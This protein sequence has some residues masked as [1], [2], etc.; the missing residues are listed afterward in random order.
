MS[1]TIE[2][3]GQSVLGYFLSNYAENMEF[4]LSIDDYTFSSCAETA[5]I[6][7]NEL[8][9][10][11]QHQELYFRNPKEALAIAAFQVKIAGDVES[12][13]ASG[14]DGYYQKIRD[15]YPQ[16]KNC[17][18][19]AEIMNSY[20]K[21]NQ[22]EL[23][24]AVKKLFASY[25]RNLE[26]PEDHSGTGKYVQY[27]V[28]AHEIPNTQLLRYADTFIRR[29]LLPNQLQISYKVFCEMFFS[30]FVKE[31]Y[32]RTVWNFYCIWDGR[33]YNE[34]ITRTKSS[35]S[36]KS[37]REKFN[38]VLEINEN[39]IYIYDKATGENIVDKKLIESFLYSNSNL[40]YFKEYDESGLY[41]LCNEPIDLGCEIVLLTE[42]ELPIDKFTIR[43]IHQPSDGVNLY[44]YICKT[45]K[46]LCSLLNL[47]IQ[48]VKAPIKF[49]GGL[50][51]RKGHYYDFALPVIEFSEEQ[52]KAFIN[53]VEVEINGNRIYLEEIKNLLKSNDGT[54]T[55]KLP[56]Y[57]PVKFK[58][59]RPERVK[60][61]NYDISGWSF[62]PYSVSPAQTEEDSSN[63]INGFCTNFDFTPIQNGVDDLGVKSSG[64]NFIKQ[65]NRFENRFLNKNIMRLTK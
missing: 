50:K 61:A 2:E 59:D 64:R 9:N 4:K 13:T 49:L 11:L 6:D 42:K 30:R 51:N 52:S 55:L 28:K 63:I 46:E 14:T 44:A 45:T 21:G 47:K 58:I 36:S 17:E 16:Y 18:Y 33:S 65:I 23:W 32:R 37:I 54:Y 56:D 57:I 34:I 41:E 26:I 31:S 20:F 40:L 19:P 39:E 60:S 3:F 62:Q 43:K 48:E 22:I 10:R 53:A 8:I 7:E 27:P 15:N 29:G 1:M 24:T 5:N 12:V 35:H 25:K 38:V